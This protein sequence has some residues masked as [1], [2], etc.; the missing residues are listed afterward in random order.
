MVVFTK[1]RNVCCSSVARW[2]DKIWGSN[3]VFFMIQGICHLSQYVDTHFR[4]P[5]RHCSNNLDWFKVE[6]TVFCEAGSVEVIK[7]HLLTAFG[8][9]W[10][11]STMRSCLVFVWIW[12]LKAV[13]IQ[14][15]VLTLY[16]FF[17]LII[18]KQHHDLQARF[19]TPTPHLHLFFCSCILYECDIYVLKKSFKHNRSIYIEL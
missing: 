10:L 6:T 5:Q 13:Q 14:V 19:A 15:T 7:W 1:L 4:V 2:Q 9:A 11:T 12:S 3:S 17:S 8:F 16:S 18:R